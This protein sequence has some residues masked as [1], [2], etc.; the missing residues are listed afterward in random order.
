[1][2]MDTLASLA[3]AYEPA[4]EEYMKEKPKKKNENILSSYMM[5]E[6]LITGTF[7]AIMCILFLKLPFIKELFVSYDSFMT[8]FFGLFIFAGIFNCFNAHTSRVNIFAHLLKNPMFI[9]IIGFISIIQTI[10]IYYGGSLFRTVPLTIKEF[11]IMILL[12]SIV[13]PIDMIRK[14]VS[15]VIKGKHVFD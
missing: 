5:S 3:F 7:T 11:T 2:V 6:I 13:I 4:L 10:M 8:A 1:M 9:I 12:A 15:K 14:K